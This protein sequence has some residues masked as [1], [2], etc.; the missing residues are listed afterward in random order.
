LSLWFG[1]GK[2]VTFWPRPD[3]ALSER[4]LIGPRS[5]S[6]GSVY[7]A[8]PVTKDQMTNPQIAAHFNTLAKLMELHKDNPFKIRSYVSAYNK[9]RK[10][11]ESLAGKTEKELQEIEGVGKAIAAKIHELAT[12]GRMETLEKWK[13]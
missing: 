1:I 2:I 13:G 4:G 6:A 9:L 11:D 12:T 8:A 3:P 10:M 7:L 5:E